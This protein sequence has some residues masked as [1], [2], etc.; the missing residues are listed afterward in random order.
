MKPTGTSALPEPAP[1]FHLPSTTNYD[2]LLAM[3]YRLALLYL[4]FT[5]LSAWSTAGDFRLHSITWP[6][7]HTS[8]PPELDQNQ[9]RF[10]PLIEAALHH[11]TE[12]SV[13]SMSGIGASMLGLDSDRATKL[14][15]QLVNYYQHMAQDPGYADMPSALAYSWSTTRPTKGLATVYLPTKPVGTIV[16]LHG[17]GGSFQFAIHFLTR[18]FPDHV[19]IAPA[20]GISST[21]IPSR[22]IDEAIHASQKQ[23]GVPFDTPPILIGLSAGG[24]GGFLEY[25][26]RPTRWKGLISIA[27]P[28]PLEQIRHQPP[29]AGQIYVLAG[30]EEYWAQPG[31]ALEQTD[32]VFGS[33]LRRIGSYQSKTIAGA[34]H[35]FLLSHPKQSRQILQSWM[36]A[37]SHRK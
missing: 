33:K 10:L 3:S 9:Q 19:L 37:L 32:R 36:R 15:H 25:C 18:C 30:G 2:R 26:R 21:H 8:T 27:S 28:A 22:Y 4:A 11:S 17:F 31:G 7:E 12:S 16:F 35:F 14:Q 20:W 13:M 24:S 34:D 5:S 1:D 6:S 29:H 23:L